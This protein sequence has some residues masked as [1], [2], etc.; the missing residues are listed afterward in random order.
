[1]IFRLERLNNNKMSKANFL[2]K[3]QEIQ[4]QK[5]MNKLRKLQHKEQTIE[6]RKLEKLE[7]DRLRSVIQ[8]HHQYSVIP[9][10]GSHARFE[11]NKLHLNPRIPT[12]VNEFTSGKKI[13]SIVGASKYGFDSPQSYRKRQANKTLDH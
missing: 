10:M 12:S 11:G 5:K 7:E 4:E 1:M 2:K 3:F 13:S 6:L 8:V 9:E